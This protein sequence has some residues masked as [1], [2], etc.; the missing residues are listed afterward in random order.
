MPFG[1]SPKA[2]GV[3]TLFIDRTLGPGRWVFQIDSV[4][5]DFQPV[6]IVNGTEYPGPAKVTLD[7]SHGTRF[8]PPREY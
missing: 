7:P 4:H 6:R 3:Q 8:I 5:F 2:D 1:V